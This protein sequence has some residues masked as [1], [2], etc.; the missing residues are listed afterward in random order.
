[1][2]RML[3]L[4]SSYPAPSETFITL[5]IQTLRAQSMQVT[6][7]ANRK[8]DFV[9]PSMQAEATQTI[10][11]SESPVFSILLA[12]LRLLLQAPLRY[13]KT[14]L[15]LPKMEAGFTASLRQFSGAAWLIAHVG[16]EAHLHVHFAYG[17]AGVALFAHLLAGVSYTV[18]LH[19]SDLLIHVDDLEKKLHHAKAIVTIS[20]FNRGWLSA[21]L[22]SVSQKTTVIRL[23][24]PHRVTELKARHPETWH[25]LTVGR[26]VEAKDQKTLI[27]AMKILEEKNANVRLTM[28]GDGPLRRALEQAAAGSAAIRFAGQLAHEEVLQL[29]QEADLFILPSISEGIPVVLMEAMQSGLPVIATN[30]TGIPELVEE[31]L[32]GFLIPPADPRALA[33]KILM[34]MHEK[35]ITEIARAA[36][37]KIARDYDLE[38]NSVIFKTWLERMA[39]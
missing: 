30:I 6:V 33:E 18:T 32:T 23:G 29:Y 15:M 8:P 21:K 16:K 26:M 35:Q 39:I 11:L 19:G 1:M 37:E 27:A 4:L 2:K 24:V 36:K 10:Y 34:A 38:T 12:H 13:L 22:P 5:Q 7:L 9:H 3:F 31:G 20:E 14:F 28:V 17:A 25:L